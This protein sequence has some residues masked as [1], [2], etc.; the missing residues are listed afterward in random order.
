MTDENTQ[1]AQL[2]EQASTAMRAIP[3]LDIHELNARRVVCANGD[4][5]DNIANQN[6]LGANREPAH[7]Y[8]PA[9]LEEVMERGQHLYSYMTTVAAYHQRDSDEELS[10]EELIQ[11]AGNM[12]NAEINAAYNN[13]SEFEF[14]G[15]TFPLSCEA[16]FDAGVAIGFESDEIIDP[17]VTDAQVEAITRDCYAAD[18]N[19]SPVLGFI[20]GARFGHGLSSATVATQQESSDRTL[21]R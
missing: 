19:V 9:V 16:A 13:S 12:R 20:A 15:R 2:E 7:E 3:F 11:R 5:P 10:D 8:C 1:I 4:M 6:N 21:S 17:I 14:E 18:K